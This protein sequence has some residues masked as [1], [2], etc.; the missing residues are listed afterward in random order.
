MPVLWRCVNTLRG[1]WGNRELALTVGNMTI[2]RRAAAG[3]NESGEYDD[4]LALLDRCA[5]RTQQDLEMLIESPGYPGIVR[6]FTCTALLNK[7]AVGDV[8]QGLLGEDP[9]TCCAL[10]R[11][12]D[13]EESPCV[14]LAGRLEL[15]AGAVR[16]Q[17]SREQTPCR[18]SLGDTHGHQPRNRADYAARLRRKWAGSR[19]SLNRPGKRMKKFR[20]Y[21]TNLIPSAT[22]RYHSTRN[23]GR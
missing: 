21:A 17:V 7:A 5:S 12:R 9:L 1:S 23:E 18:W 11:L 19:N 16:S 8:R 20:N 3:P 4:A 10:M 6:R 2:A 14:R 22:H 15:S 13:F